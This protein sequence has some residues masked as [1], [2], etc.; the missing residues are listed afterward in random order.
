MNENVPQIEDAKRVTSRINA[1]TNNSTSK[2]I[3]FKL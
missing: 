1:K 3:I 2:H